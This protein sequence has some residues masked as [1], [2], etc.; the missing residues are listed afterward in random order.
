MQTKNVPAQIKAA[1]QEGEQPEGRFTAV[2]S[3]FNT[4]DSVNDVV[5]PGAFQKSLA[6]WE[7][8]GTPLPVVWSHDWNDPFSHIGYVVD[9]KETDTGLQVTGQ[10][11][12]DN[13]KAKQV[14]NL[15]KGGRIRNWSFSYDIDN[16]SRGER[17]GKSVQELHELTVHEVGPCLVGAHRSTDTVEVKTAAVS[18]AI[19]AKVDALEQKLK[20]LANAQENAGTPSPADRVKSVVADIAALVA[21]LMTDVD[22]PEFKAAPPGFTPKPIIAR[23]R[24]LVAAAQALLDAVEPGSSDDSKA[25]PAQP[26]QPEP[27]PEGSAAGPDPARQGAASPSRLPQELDLVKHRLLELELEDEA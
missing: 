20:S 5:L 13:P 4:V 1:P 11:D 22:A 8:K 14:F 19:A 3:V 23:I 7:A 21:E 18:A 9:A 25:M 16:A 27:A 26:S 6:D 12:L 15:L 17:N 10:L 2:V 24:K